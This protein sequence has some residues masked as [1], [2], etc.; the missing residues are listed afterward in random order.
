MVESYMPFPQQQF[1]FYHFV[2][3]FSF[4][5]KISVYLKIKQCDGLIV[6]LSSV[7][8]G[9]LNIIQLLVLFYHAVHCVDKFEV[10]GTCRRTFHE[11]A[12]VSSLICL[13]KLAPFH[14]G[15]ILLFS[16]MQYVLF[17]SVLCRLQ[18]CSESK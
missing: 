5:V 16:L 1:T 18:Y 3:F 10:F 6:F 12:V 8:L 15:I 13:C 7:G 11:S 4:R 9:Y 17:R 14:L 2:I